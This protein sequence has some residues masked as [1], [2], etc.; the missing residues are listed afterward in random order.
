M[1]SKLSKNQFIERAVKIHGDKFDYS[2]LIYERIRDKGVIICKIHG[3][4]HQ[5]LSNH[6][7]SVGCMRR[8]A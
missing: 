6:L 7:S 2:K 4:F 5:T 1:S 8:F 3:E